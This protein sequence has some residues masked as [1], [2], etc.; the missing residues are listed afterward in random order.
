MNDSNMSYVVKSDAH[1]QVIRRN[2]QFLKPAEKSLECIQ[3]NPPIEDVTDMI[4]NNP[5]Q[6]VKDEQQD[7]KEIVPWGR[8]GHRKRLQPTI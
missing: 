2:R 8:W 3:T 7:A 1:N 4:K 6:S 5:L